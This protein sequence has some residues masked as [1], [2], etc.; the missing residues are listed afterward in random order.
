[1]NL[2]LLTLLYPLKTFAGMQCIA[3]KFS[4]SPLIHLQTLF[5]PG[6]FYSFASV[7][8]KHYSYLKYHEI[9]C[10]CC[11]CYDQR[12][13]AVVGVFF[14]FIISVLVS[15]KTKLCQ[16]N[17]WS[18]QDTFVIETGNFYTY[19][20]RGGGSLFCKCLEVDHLI[21]CDN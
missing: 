17:S 16:L 3:F 12:N 15:F 14:S 10:T 6:F 13:I 5:C 7:L 19:L 20:C 18:L 11:F 9:Q 8:M 21:S 1:M 2:F 4:V